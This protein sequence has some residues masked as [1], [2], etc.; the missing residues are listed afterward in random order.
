MPN[1]H[2]QPN[3]LKS[4][5]SFKKLNNHTNNKEDYGG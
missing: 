5:I 1:T 2:T 4:T 3:A